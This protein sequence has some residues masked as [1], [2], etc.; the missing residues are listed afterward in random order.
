MMMP[1]F[2]PGIILER[3]DDYFTNSIFYP[4]K[5]D[6]CEVDDNEDMTSSTVSSC[7]VNSEN[8]EL[9]NQCLNA[10]SRWSYQRIPSDDKP[11]LPSITSYECDNIARMRDGLKLSSSSKGSSESKYYDAFMQFD[12]TLSGEAM[13]L[14]EAPSSTSRKS[15]FCCFCQG[16]E[17]SDSDEESDKNDDSNKHELNRVDRV[18]NVNMPLDPNDTQLLYMSKVEGKCN[19]DN[20]LIISFDKR[21]LDCDDSSGYSST[22]EDKFMS[23]C[24]SKEFLQVE[25]VYT[26][27]GSVNGELPKV[28]PFSTYIRIC[29]LN[30]HID[31][32]KETKRSAKSTLMASETMLGPSSDILSQATK[33]KFLEFTNIN[34]HNP[35]GTPYHMNVSQIMSTMVKLGSNMALYNIDDKNNSPF[36]NWKSEGSTKKLIRSLRSN[37]N[38]GAKWVQNLDSINLLEKEVMLWSGHPIDCHSPSAIYG[39]KIPFFKARGI[40]PSIS[41]RE[42]TEL[43]LDSS[44][45]KLYNK[46]TNGRKDLYVFQENIDT[47]DGLYGDGCL[48]IVQSETNIPFSNKTLK[49]ANLLHAR[50]IQVH[51]DDFQRIFDYDDDGD[52]GYENVN[53]YIIVSRSICS[54]SHV[55]EEMK[56]GKASS[57]SPDLGSKN[58]VLWGVNIL[59]EVPGHPNKTD[60]TTLTQANSSAVP[61]FMSRKVRYSIVFEYFVFALLNLNGY[62]INFLIM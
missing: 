18:E 29:D 8:D 27:N 6:G 15:L 54:N 2:S 50:P 20:V 36:I 32:E 13:N 33:M 30:I 62:M 46:Y 42:L 45:V 34:D 40:I 51:H 9:I 48:K 58:E 43:I 61:S 52:E 14:L 4:M 24:D 16:L 17:C 39:S 10:E 35:Q 21:E 37:T 41:P 56:K 44:R 25:V 55:S 12:R 28:D 38:G 3:L 31:D 26:N 47:V 23:C 59:R 22:S 7:C 57:Q 1:F 53:A 5:N 11:P 60:L 49:I 19:D